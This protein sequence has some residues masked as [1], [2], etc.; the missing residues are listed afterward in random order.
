MTIGVSAVSIPE[1]TPA[2]SNNAYTEIVLRM[3]ARH[4]EH[5]F[6]LFFDR[7][8]P[9]QL[10]LPVNATPV[11]LPLKGNARW[12]RRWWWQWQLHRALLRHRPAVFLAMDGMLPLRSRIPA[13]LFINDLSFLQG[14]AGMPGKW[15]RYLQRQTVQYVDKAQKVLLLTGALRQALLEYAPAAAGKLR[16]LPAAVHESYHPLSWEE[17]EAVKQQYTNGVEYFIVTGALHP[18]NNIT[19]LLKAFSALKRRLHSNM[20]L[21]LAGSPTPAGLEIADS[22]RTYRFRQDVV[23]LQEPDQ[24]ALAQLTAAAYA[25]IY[26]TRL[27]GT[28]LPVYAALQCEVPVIALDGP[29]AREA[30]KDALLYADPRRQEDLADKLCLL[31]KDEQLRARLLQ[32]MAAL[33]RTGGWDACADELICTFAY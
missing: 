2:D 28:A 14:A 11:V 3:C 6:I 23:W 31:Y 26:T 24:A 16:V 13:V 29:A 4:P 30:G 22:L 15:Q 5:S 19:P 10:S 32:E 25:M 27:A 33:P 18:R 17:R 12:R 21:V 20:K 1:D 7:P 8:V 9:P